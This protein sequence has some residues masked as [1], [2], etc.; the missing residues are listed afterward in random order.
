MVAGRT[1]NRGT[2]KDKKEHFFTLKQSNGRSVVSQE[3]QQVDCE[4]LQT[5]QS[6]Q[7]ISGVSI[8][9]RTGP[10]MTPP[11]NSL[12]SPHVPWCMWQEAVKWQ[13]QGSLGLAAI[14]DIGQLSNS[15]LQTL[16]LK[17][18]HMQL[19]KR[20]DTSVLFFKLAMLFF[21]SCTCKTYSEHCANKLDTNTDPR[22][23]F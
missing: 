5:H 20:V 15:N 22:I 19:E 1:T 7:S 17:G 3:I 8:T 6:H 2:L 12:T 13:K 18:L 14:G 23:C 11:W 10:M 21:C 16:F 4:T 9:T